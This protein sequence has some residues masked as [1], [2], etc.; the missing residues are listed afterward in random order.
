MVYIYIYTPT[1]TVYSYN[2]CREIYKSQ[3]ML[4]VWYQPR[5]PFKIIIHVLASSLI[6]P[7]KKV[8]WRSF[9]MVFRKYT[10]TNCHVLGRER[11]F[12]NCSWCRWLRW[13]RQF[14]EGRNYIFH[15]FSTGKMVIP[16]GWWPLIFSLPFAPHMKICGYLLGPNPFKRAATGG[17]NS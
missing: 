9:M 17:L 12:S 2:K 14:V 7:Q 13:S 11:V 3:W 16:L 4:W 6:S 5:N 1:W 10:H 15:F 8:A